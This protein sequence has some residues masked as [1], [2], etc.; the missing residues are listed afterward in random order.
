MKNLSPLAQQLV[1]AGRNAGAPTDADKE[2]IR[3][4]LHQ[5]LALPPGPE[6]SALQGPGLSGTPSAPWAPI[7]GATIAAGL[8]AGLLYWGATRDAGAPAGSAPAAAPQP[9]V[10]SPR[11][12]PPSPPAPRAESSS[13][14]P[15]DAV[16]AAPAVSVPSPQAAATLRAKSRLA[17]EVAL[18]SRA[19]SALH[20][21]RAQDALSALAE[22]Q[23][24]FPRGHLALERV[25]ARAQ[26]LCQL[27]RN[28]EAEREL[29]RL[30]PTSPQAVRARR[31][32]GGR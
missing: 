32:C 9:T 26:A 23:Q 1:K 31:A 28:R 19:T 24:E 21:G 6:P 2:R 17:E 12:A 30:S 27:G 22:H 13:V 16:V 5:Q 4:A 15:P 14:A 10:V 8:V 25:A 7:A 11:V 18:L 3:E 20:A 29:G